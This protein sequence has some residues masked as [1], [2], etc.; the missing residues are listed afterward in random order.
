VTRRLVLLSMLSSIGCL[1]YF[2]MLDRLFLSSRNFAPIFQLLL[3]GY[4]A[5]VAWLAVAVCLLAAL[6]KR[7]GPI[8]HLVDFLSR[9][10]FGVALTGVALM[11]LGSI[12][13][14]HSYPFSMD[15]YAAVF[16]SKIFASGRVVAQLPPTMVDWLVTPNFHGGFL[17]ASAETGQTIEGYWPGFSLLLAP[18]EFLNVPWLCN[19]LLGGSAIYLLYRITFEITGDRRAAG[20][21]ILFAVASGVFLAD[22]IS[23]Y[24]MQAHLTLNLLFAWLLLRPTR[25]R[26]FAAGLVGSFAL[27]LHNPFPHFLF[28]LPWIVSIAVNKDARQFI[29]PLIA[30]Y[31]PITLSVG[32]GWII[33]TSSIAPVA[34]GVALV[35]A[36]TSGVFSWPNVN[37][38]NMR[39]AALAKMLV[40]AVP[41]LFVL[42]AA[43]WLRLRDNLHVRLLTQSAAL[44]FL[45]YLFVN[46]DQGHGWGYRYFHSAWGVIPILAACAMTGRSETDGRFESFAGAG[47]ILS[48]LIIVPFQ[49]YQIEHII[50]RHLN[51]LPPPVRPG[52]DIFF[53]STTTGFYLVDMIQNDPLLRAPDLL[54]A[55]HG[56]AADAELRRRLWPNAKK[57]RDGRWGQ[58]WYLGPIDQRVSTAAGSDDKRWT[59]GLN[60]PGRS[61]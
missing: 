45:G 31:L 3:T 16:Q 22:A 55:S 10:P 44:T 28:A 54:L 33:L 11:G 38:L 46:L 42:A 21:A 36:S 27:V 61:P 37:I 59:F 4:D 19:A 7:P 48:L 35:P 50:S 41:G 25:S 20:W 18:C 14:Y 43:G 58:Q 15:E 5:Q 57:I 53:V 8:L 51:E 24:S 2:F 49:M 40:W 39:A 30:G 32:L 17:T 26:A 34:H 12:F 6:W 1:G 29:W 13:I 60:A 56:A 47:S 9:H 23:Y 52:N